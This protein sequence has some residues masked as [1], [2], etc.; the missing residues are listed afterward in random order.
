VSGTGWLI[1]Y[2]DGMRVTEE[3]IRR[4]PSHVP[5]LVGFGGGVNSTSMLVE[6]KRRDLKPDLI[7]F[8]DTR[9]EKPESYA[10]LP[11]MD[12][13]LY[14]NGFPTL[15][16]VVNESP[17]RGD[18]SLE[19]RCLRNKT[20]P[21]RAFGRSSCS[22]AWKIEPQEKFVSRW[23]PAPYAW[24]QG[25]KVIKAL[26]YDLDEEY[27]ATKHDDDEKKRYR[28]A[29]PLMEWA[30]DREDC[31]TAIRDAGLPVPPKS[32]CFFCPASV[33]EEI[34]WLADTHPD[35]FARAIEIERRGVAEMDAEAD[36][37]ERETG[38]RPERTVVGLGRHWTWESVIRMTREQ[39]A[40]LP[41]PAPG[42][43]HCNDGDAC[44]LEAA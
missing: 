5:F 39:R 1:P 35:L 14:R 44:E 33:P 28:Y 8:A 15:T 42:C 29:Y 34:V 32:A 22:F 17:V 38:K 19:A 6:L 4:R 3:D 9:G 43:I 30:W 24:A 13:W 37:V 23:A 11:R 36:R 16:I 31:V 26:G 41:K 27:R 25:E 18:V 2:G 12:E 21:S 20:L 10:F 7:T 40:K